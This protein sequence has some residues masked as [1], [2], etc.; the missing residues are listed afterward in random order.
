MNRRELA[1][2]VVISVLLALSLVSS[3]HAAEFK[4][5]ASDGAADDEFG[6]S[7]AIDGEYALVGAYGDDDNGNYSGS[8]YVFKRD[9]SSWTQQAK[10]VAS[11]GAAGDYFG[12]SVAI[13]GEYSLV[14]AYGD[15][16]N[17]STSGSAYVFKRDGSSWT[18]QAKLVASDGAA[19][20]YFGY[21]VALDG[22]YA[23]MGAFLDDDKGS[24]SGSAY[25]FKRDGS[26]WTQ[27]AKLVASDG[28]V[29]DYFGYSVAID[30]EYALVGAYRDDDK[31]TNSGSAYVVWGSCGDVTGDGTVDVADVGRL[32]YHV[33]FPGDPRYPLNCWRLS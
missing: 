30:G 6:Y 4:L 22:E 25:V 26:S 15:D 10:L 20:D 16:D 32:L 5:T 29:D 17:G 14:G 12:Y 8:A 3:V 7:V 28:A 24:K 1:F 9:G 27:Q 19:G 21:S 13:D 2:Y 18:Q 23:L 11:D 33:G 31:G